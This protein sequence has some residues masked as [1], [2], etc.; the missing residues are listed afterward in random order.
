MNETPKPLYPGLYGW[1]V[2]YQLSDGSVIFCT[3]FREA[4]RCYFGFLGEKFADNLKKAFLRFA[5]GINPLT[6]KALFPECGVIGDEP[7]MIDGK[8]FFFSNRN[9]KAPRLDGNFWKA[10]EQLFHFEDKICEVCTERVP[11]HFYCH[12]MYGSPFA[13][14]YGAWVRAELIRKGF[15]QW[16]NDADSSIRRK[17]WN[18]AE[19]KIRMIVGVPLIGEKFISETILFKTVAYLLNSHEVIHHYRADWLGRQELDIFVPSLKLAIEYQGEQHFKPVDA[20]G[21][22][23]A[24]LRGQRRDDEKKQKCEQA[25]VKLIYFDYRT[26]LSEKFVARQL[27]QTLGLKLS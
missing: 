20:W 18:E 13:Q 11:K 24:L 19:D 17:L 3:C 1:Q 12:Q 2:A 22:E 8:E 16:P 9:V 23:E 27:E 26:E 7:Q 6:L 10:H 21:G 14:V 15:F 5:W 4:W 25:G